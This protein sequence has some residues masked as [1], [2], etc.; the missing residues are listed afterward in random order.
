MSFES[1]LKAAV[2]RW[3]HL[4]LGLDTELEKLPVPFSKSPDSI[5][6]FNLEMIELSSGW[7]AAYKPNLGFYEALGGAGWEIL[8]KT[9]RAVPKDKIILLDGKRGDI[10]NTARMYARAMFDELGGDALTVNPYLG[11]DSLTPF[12]ENPEKGIYLL[13]LT[14]N[15]GASDFQLFPPADPLY[16]RVARRASDW[17]KNKNIGL[18]AGA[19]H[20][21]QLASVREAAPAL[22]FLIPGVGAQGGSL[23]DAVRY[24]TEGGKIPSLVNLSR[25]VL[26]ASSGPDYKEKAE[27]E[28]K[29]MKAEID[30]LLSV[31]V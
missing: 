3:G 28:L 15:S 9:C 16:L 2:A 20:P 10:G 21:A 18:V 23:A 17:N 13:C 12:I 27:A 29:K 25:S 8:K 30:S 6:K 22:P 31:R 1:K 14:S 4:S 5:L 24:G 19:T 11:S 26:Y 7:A